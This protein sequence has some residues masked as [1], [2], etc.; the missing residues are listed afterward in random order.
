MDKVE[1]FK[2]HLIAKTAGASDPDL[3]ARFAQMSAEDQKK[4]EE[5]AKKWFGTK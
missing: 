3:D 2:W 1:G 5:G 4:A